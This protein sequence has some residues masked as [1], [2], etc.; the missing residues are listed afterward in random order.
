MRFWDENRK[1]IKGLIA[2]AV[3]ILLAKYV[4]IGRYENMVVGVQSERKELK[5]QLVSAAEGR[6]PIKLAMQGYRETNRKLIDRKDSLKKQLQVEFPGWTGI[7]EGRDPAEY[8]RTEFSKRRHDLNTLC[9]GRVNLDDP[10][11]GFEPKA[12]LNRK[13]A[14]EDLRRLSIVEKLVKLLVDAKVHT[15]RSI[16][17]DEPSLTGA[18]LREKNPAYKANAK[19]AALKQKYIITKYPEFIREYP[20][21]IELFSELDPLMKF[22]HSV[23]QENQFLVILSLD[24]RS[25]AGQEDSDGRLLTPGMLKVVITAA[26]M[27]FLTEEEVEEI[28]KK[29]P[30]PKRAKPGTPAA[31]RPRPTEPIGA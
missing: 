27:S 9:A 11:L 28:E 14:Q 8:F 12:K 17:H 18:F 2:A 26:G 6:Q 13:S 23:R 1:L 25:A 24:I 22:L 19:I 3:L 16:K 31:P 20:T 4:V 5:P 15:V 21:R 30:T 7:P 10:N 29:M